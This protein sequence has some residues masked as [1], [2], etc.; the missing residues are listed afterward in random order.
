MIFCCSRWATTHGIAKAFMPSVCLSVRLSVK[1]MDFDKTKE[2]CAHIPIP[3][4]R[5][6]ILVF[7]PEEQL[8]GNDPILGQT[9]DVRARTSIYN[10]YSFQPQHVAEKSLITT[11]RQTNTSYP[12]SL[13]RTSYNVLSPHRGLKNAKRQFSV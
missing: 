13:R 1:R 8:V 10:R 6:C 2:I 9:D 4:E 3:Y 12:M 5:T 11:I 7:R